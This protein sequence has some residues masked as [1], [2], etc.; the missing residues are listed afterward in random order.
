M[1]KVKLVTI[2]FFGCILSACGN[3]I[4]PSSAPIITSI[5]TPIATSTLEAI[6]SPTAPAISSNPTAYESVYDLRFRQFDP[7]APF[8]VNASYPNEITSIGDAELLRLGCSPE[9]FSWTGADHEFV[10]PI[11]QERNKINDPS[12]QAF[13][14]SA[15]LLHP[16]K[17]I[18]SISYC[19]VEN[20]NPIVIYRVGDCGGGCA[21]IPTIFIGKSDHSLASE[22]VIQDGADGAYYGCAPLLLT[23]QHVLY[24]TC[25]GEGTGIVRKVDLITATVE[26]VQ[27]CKETVNGVICD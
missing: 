27:S 13:L 26:S 16:G 6:P 24:V 12:M 1:H 8:F 21:G 2:I 15:Q 11:T 18:T 4:N 25:Q 20:E 14:A 3:G 5:L 23:I 19:E 17:G 10:D 9:Y 7:T 22:T